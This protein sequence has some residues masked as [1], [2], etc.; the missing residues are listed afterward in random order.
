VSRNILD[1]EIIKIME[2]KINSHAVSINSK[3]K[4]IEIFY[5]LIKWVDNDDK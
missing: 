3:T 4:I 1:S 2:Q 5:N